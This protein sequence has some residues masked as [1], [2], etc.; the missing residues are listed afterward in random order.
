MRDRDRNVLSLPKGQMAIGTLV[1]GRF[2][3]QSDQAR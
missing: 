2:S 3:D 1:I